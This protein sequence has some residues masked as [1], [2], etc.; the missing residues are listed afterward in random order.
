MHTLPTRYQTYVIVPLAS[1]IPTGYAASVFITGPTGKQRAFGVL[2]YFASE[3][4]ACQF[5]V[6]YAKAHIDGTA[7]PTPPLVP[8]G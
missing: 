2:G 6:S 1:A 3:R 5:A 4:A 8:L 7:L